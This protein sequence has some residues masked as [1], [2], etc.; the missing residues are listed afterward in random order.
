[1]QG[2]Y[3]LIVTGEEATTLHPRVWS[4]FYGDGLNQAAGTWSALHEVQGGSAGLGITYGRPSVVFAS[5]AWRLWVGEHYTGALGYG[6]AQW[7]TMAGAQ[8]FT[9]ELWREPQSFF[10]NASFAVWA[11]GASGGVFLCSASSVWYASNSPAASD[12]SSRIVDCSAQL[13]PF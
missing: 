4:I 2:D 13:D 9:D 8:T 5:S 11:A 10:A 7:S 1:Y 6:Q 12:Y 3:C